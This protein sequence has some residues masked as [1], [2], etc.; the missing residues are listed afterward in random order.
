MTNFYTVFTTIALLTVVA[1][2]LGLPVLPRR[3]QI[4]STSPI[5]KFWGKTRMGWNQ[6]LNRGIV[7]SSYSY[8]WIR[9][10]NKQS[11]TDVLFLHCRQVWSFIHT[12][13]TFI[14]LI[15]NMMKKKTIFHLRVVTLVQKSRTIWSMV[16]T[17]L[18]N[19]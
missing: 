12:N 2:Y 7:V 4:T 17:P 15:S 9:S 1:G 8:K 3:A 18:V 6:S 16:S 11:T 13:M 14:E 19:V 10:C 5:C